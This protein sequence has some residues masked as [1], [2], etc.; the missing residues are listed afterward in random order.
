M[1]HQIDA[2]LAE[3]KEQRDFLATRA[4]QLAA[5]LAAAKAEIER[6]NQ[7]QPR[8]RPREDVAPVASPEPYDT[9]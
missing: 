8:P 2:L 6:L 5:D 4:L 9:I 3:V 1:Q 7:A